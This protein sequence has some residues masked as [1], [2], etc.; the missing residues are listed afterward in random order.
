MEL[1]L[2]LVLLRIFL[3]IGLGLL[4]LIISGQLS[5][6]FLRRQQFECAQKA[7]E[8]WCFDSRGLRQEI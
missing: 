3:G 8:D 7:V 2:A 4:D 5:E 6:S 1:V